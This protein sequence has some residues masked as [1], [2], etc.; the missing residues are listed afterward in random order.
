M[1]DACGNGVDDNCN[2]LIDEGI[3]DIS[4]GVGVCRRTVAACVLGVTQTCVPGTAT[5]EI[6][7]GLDDYCDGR[8]DEGC[9]CALGEAPG[10]QLAIRG[11]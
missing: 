9:G 5:S 8:V 3:P 2:G 11:L 10:S 6:C 4:C 7:N 1:T